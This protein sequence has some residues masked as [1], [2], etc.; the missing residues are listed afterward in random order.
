MKQVLILSFASLLCFGC[1]GKSEIAKIDKKPNI[2]FILTDDQRWD[3]IIFSETWREER[4][5]TLETEH[6]HT[7]FGSGVGILLHKTR[8]I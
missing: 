6:G 1:S 7:W 3:A 4:H 5:E 8:G 2:I